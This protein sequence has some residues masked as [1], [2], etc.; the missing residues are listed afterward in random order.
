M[1]RYRYVLYYAV[2]RLGKLQNKLEKIYY[3]RTRYS[4]TQDYTGHM[5]EY[6]ARYNFNET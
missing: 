3:T 5:I 2:K 1:G 6:D 4:V